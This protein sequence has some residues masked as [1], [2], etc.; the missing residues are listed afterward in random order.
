MKNALKTLGI[1]ALV[2]VIGFSM[3]ACSNGGGGS[4]NKD[5]GGEGNADV[6]IRT[7]NNGGITPNGRAIGARAV[8]LY[9]ND[10][11]FDILTTFYSKLG[12]K[13]QA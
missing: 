1:I 10:L 11:S 9:G 7:F 4:S 13:K 8:G 3:I 12:T 6:R 2:A 5:T